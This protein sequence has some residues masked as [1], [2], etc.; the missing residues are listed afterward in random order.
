MYWQAVLNEVLNK[1]TAYPALFT[2][3][4]QKRIKTNKR[5]RPKKYKTYPLG[6]KYGSTYFTKRE[7]ECALQLIQGKTINNTAKKLNI[8]PR[9]V[10][11]Y[12]KNIK[13]KLN[14]RTK[15]QLIGEVLHSDFLTTVDFPC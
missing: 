3:I 13:T 7:A 15:T 8:S 4:K 6:K 9:T 14:C 11:F 10:E 1:N 5:I 2:N 12:I